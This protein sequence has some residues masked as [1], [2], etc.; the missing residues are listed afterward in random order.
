MEEIGDWRLDGCLERMN[1]H[2]DRKC[3][4]DVCAVKETA[5]GENMGGNRGDADDD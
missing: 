2:L 4:R 5:T 3:G 1:G